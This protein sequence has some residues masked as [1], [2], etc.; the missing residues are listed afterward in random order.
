MFQI[1]GVLVV[2]MLSMG[3][4]RRKIASHVLLTVMIGLALFATACGGS[5]TTSKTVPPPGGGT[6]PGTYT[7]L[8]TANSGTV[9]HTV[10]LTLT[11]Q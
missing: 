7:M 10:P 3:T 5:P 11:V 9:T 1:P 2:G 8:V 4:K 6:A